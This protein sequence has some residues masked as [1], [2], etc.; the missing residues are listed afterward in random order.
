MFPSVIFTMP[1]WGLG[2]KPHIKDNLMRAAGRVVHLTYHKCGSQWVRD[3]LTAPE[4]LPYSQTPLYG[5]GL[6]APDVVW[7][8][9]PDHTFMGPLYGVSYDDW[10]RHRRDDDKAVVVLRD[11]RDRL[12]SLVYSQTY[13]HAT[14]VIGDR[15]RELYLRLDPYSR[16]MF[17]LMLEAATYGAS[18]RSWAEQES[19]P[20]AYITSYEKLIADSVGEYG[21]IV[22]FLGWSVPASVLRAVVDRLSFERRSGR[23]PGNEDVSSHYRMG[24]AG[25]WRRHFDARLGE[26]HEAMLPSLVVAL[27]Y[28]SNNDWYRSLPEA[29]ADDP[30]ARRVR[31]EKRLV[32]LQAEVTRLHEANLALHEANFALREANSSSREI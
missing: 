17:A 12:V 32:D 5:G 7:S 24:K 18:L 16:L 30:S 8:A 25:D 14:D 27:G 6:L 9:Q 1:F 2:K 23:K 28:E 31:E 22:R 15:F 13:S 3:V 29:L 20:A 11:P 21:R 10:L 4:L 19:S 26:L